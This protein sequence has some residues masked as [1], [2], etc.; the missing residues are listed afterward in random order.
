MGFDI[1]GNQPSTVEG[2]YF[3]NSCCAWRPLAHYVCTIAPDITNQCK[4]WHTND[5]DGLDAKHAAA[6][7]DR[8]DIEIK[9]GRCERYAQIFSSEQEMAPDEPCFLCESTGTRKPIPQ[10][11]AGDAIT[12]IVCNCCHGKGTIR[13]WWTQYPFSVE[14]VRKFIVFLRGCGGFRIG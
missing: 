4:Y 6:L 3:H 12:G 9:D 7:A 1:V 8:L 11:G 2:E 13:P 5:Y 10:R 14:N